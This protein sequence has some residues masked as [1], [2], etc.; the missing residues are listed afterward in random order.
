MTKKLYYLKTCD[1]CKRILKDINT[2]AFIIR[3]IKSEP[4]TALE[5]DMLYNYTKSYESLLN[6]RAQKLRLIDTAAFL[7]IDY[8]NL[9]LQDYTFLKRPIFVD[10]DQIFI[11]NDKNTI[12]AL[13]KKYQ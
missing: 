8:R 1:T 12:S 3:E 6:K 11:G 13:H 2:N 4:I 10:D 5:L 9:I 7:D